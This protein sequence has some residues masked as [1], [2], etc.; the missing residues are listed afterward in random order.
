MSEK[1][2]WPP[3]FHERVDRLVQ[4]HRRAR[5]RQIVE[6]MTQGITERRIRFADAEMLA[7]AYLGLV[8]QCNLDALSNTR[9]RQPNPDDLVSLF[10]NG[11]CNPAA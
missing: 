11:A 2:N 8:S 9:R 4:K 5:R 1:A 10:M 6:L 7:S 3:A